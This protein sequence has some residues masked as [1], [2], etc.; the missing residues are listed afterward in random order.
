MK[1]L[2]PTIASSKVNQLLQI[3]KKAESLPPLSVGEVV[4]AE[5]LKNPRGGKVLILLKN[6]RVI[7][8]SALPFERGEKI[9][10]RVAQLHPR[11]I[12]RIIQN[13]EIFEKSGAARECLSFYRSNPKGLFE[14][15]AKG[16]DMF[17]PENSG[18][19]AAHLGEEDVKDIRNIL[20]SLIFSKE[21]SRNNL[22]LKDYIH[23]L[24]Y[25]ME[26]GLGKALKKKFGKT[27]SLKNSS[28]N[29]KGLLVKAYDR[30]QW[31]METKNLLTAEKLAGFVRSSLKTIE[32]HQ[33]INYLFQEYEGKYMF[34]IPMLFPENMGM[35]EI[36]VKFENQDSKGRGRRGE[37]KV[38]FLL[39]M[40]VLGDVVVET[41]IKKKNIG[42]AFKCKDKNISDF[43]EPF[44]GE[45]GE[46]L[47]ALGYEI[48]YLRCVAEKD[49]AGI[50]DEYVEFRTLF[51]RGSVD[52]IV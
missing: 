23:N 17:S 38:L 37:K 9:A 34:Q 52:I 47:T 44:L 35:A 14:L 20:K 41:V 42:C 25:L 48:D 49:H 50:R 16:V 21:G 51:A 8:D 22:F 15:F 27:P 6:S 36:F 43:I 30:L 28:Q 13:D 29:L 12:L 11:V 39:N 5:I 24:G 3:Q 32:S 19:L 26:N 1:I 33:L 31:L 7:A 10:V 4:E 46:K 45:L 2:P 40:D 18:E